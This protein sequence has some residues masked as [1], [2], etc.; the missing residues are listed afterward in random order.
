[1]SSTIIARGP[2][3]GWPDGLHLRNGVVEATVATTIGPRI[4]GLRLAGGDDLFFQ[5]PAQ[6][7]RSGESSYRVRGGW[8]L[9]IAPEQPAISAALDNEPCQV[10]LLGDGVRVTGAPQ[11]AAGVQKEIELMLEPGEPHVRLISRVRN[12]GDRELACAGWSLPMFRRGGRAFLPLD[13]GPARDYA[14]LRRLVLWSY[15]RIADPRYRIGDRLIQV[16]QSEVPPPTETPGRPSDESKLGTD[17]RQGWAAYLLDRTLFVKRFEVDPAGV[18]PHGGAT[19]EI[20]TCQ[21]LVELEH[22]GPVTRLGPR[23]ALELREDWWLFGDV[24]IPLDEDGALAALAP[25]LARTAPR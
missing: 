3:L 20:F 19:T 16:D 7:G 13:V 9:W 17:S 18:Y 24:S 4:M 12:V 21:A 25:Y 10:E 1:V 5:V 6:L 8:R 23:E 15:T 14:S 2:L 22:L 11:P